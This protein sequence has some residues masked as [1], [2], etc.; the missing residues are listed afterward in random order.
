MLKFISFFYQ[1][2][3][4]VHMIKK[5]FITVLVIILVGM[6]AA[7]IGLRIWF[8]TEIN[9]IC[10]NA[11]NRYEGDKIEA[12]IALLNDDDQSLK[13]KNNAIWAL[14]KLNDQRALPTLRRLQ[15]G[16]ECNHSMY[17]CQ[18]ELEKAIDNL[19]G[20][21]IDILTFR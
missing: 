3:Y 1:E 15:T 12:L 21:G 10:D 14:G 11:M 2:S 19:E 18:H 9:Q 8:K 16:N 4:K 7:Y 6:G 13:T 20:R 5:V 17:V